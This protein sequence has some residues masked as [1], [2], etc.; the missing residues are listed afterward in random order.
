MEEVMLKVMAEVKTRWMYDKSEENR[1]DNR[2]Q[3]KNTYDKSD[4]VI[5]TANMVEIQNWIPIYYSFFNR[6]F[7][8][9][10]NKYVSKGGGE[11]GGGEIQ[12]SKVKK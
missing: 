2:L 6:D 3:N 12:F 7:P 5:M 11:G 9:E 1:N 4:F 10:K 8:C